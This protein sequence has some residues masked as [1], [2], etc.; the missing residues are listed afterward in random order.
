[1]GGVP[2]PVARR[3]EAGRR[4]PPSVDRSAFHLEGWRAAAA[5]LDVDIVELGDGFLRLDGWLLVR[6][7]TVGVDSVATWQLAGDKG[8]ARRLLVDAGLPVTVDRPADRAHLR[9]LIERPTDARGLVIKP[10]RDTGAGAGVTVGPSTRREVVAAITEARRLSPAVQIEEAVDGDIVR[11]LVVEGE[12]LDAVVRR[13]ARVQGD[14]RQT[15]DELVDAENARRRSL[16]GGP[17]GFI[18]RTTDYR[19]QLRRQRRSPG[20]RL[21]LG[22]RITVSGRSN[23]GSELESRRTTLSAEASRAAIDACRALGVRIGGVDL[24]VDDGRLSAVLEVNTTPGLHWHTLVADEPFPVFERVL[25]AVLTSHR[26]G[27]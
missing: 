14:G 13:P 26:G 21:Q 22:E 25:A 10:S 16:P 17:T 12:L 6:G 2:R 18:P 11:A 1:M 23:T 24:V 9:Q 7:A 8:V 4:Y 3:L 15:V 27:H 19:V 20:A 5:S